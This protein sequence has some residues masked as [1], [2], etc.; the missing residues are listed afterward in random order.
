M[1]DAQLSVHSAAIGVPSEEA[2]EQGTEPHVEFVIN[3]GL[4]LPFQNPQN[5]EPL[6]VPIGA[7]RL[8]FTKEQALELFKSGVE[9]AE[10]LPDEKAHGK[11]QIAS[12]IS[13][14]ERAAEQMKRFQGQ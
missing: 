9:A 11:L 6:L 4:A 13:E 5:G 12:N 3:P 10:T 8:H 1:F 2:L 7:L 14:V